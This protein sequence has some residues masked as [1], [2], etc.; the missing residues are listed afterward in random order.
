MDEAY[1]LLVITENQVQLWPFVTQKAAQEA[2]D[3][4]AEEK[5]GASW[6]IISDHD[7]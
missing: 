2:A 5:P 1:I 6:K 4:L 3:F 7:E